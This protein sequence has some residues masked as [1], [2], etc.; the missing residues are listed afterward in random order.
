MPYNLLFISGNAKLTQRLQGAL[1]GEA[2]LMMADPRNE[3]G[4]SLATR[5]DP[6][7]LIV[8]AGTHTGAKTVL[9]SIAAM[10]QKFPTLPLIV[11]GDE[12]SAQLIL[13]SF[14]AGANDFLDRES[15]DTELRAAILSRLR[16][17]PA[18]ANRLAS[19]TLIDILSPAPSDE[20]FD[21]ALN[22]A[23]LIA[24]GD[25]ERR[26]L[27]LDFS[28]PASPARLALG[29]ELNFAMPAAIRD[30]AR[31]DR[32]YLDSALA[33]SA[34][35][36]LYVLPLADEAAVANSLPALRDVLVLL[37]MLRSLFDMV[38][39]YWGAFSRQAALSGL[40]GEN[41]HIF[42][43][44]NQRFASIRNAKSL[45]AE[46]EGGNIAHVDP[47]IVIHQLAHNT[48]PT[49]DDMVRAIGGNK[50]L[51][52]RT[53]SAVLIHA[54]NRGRPLSL[55]GP[56]QYSDALRGYLVAAGLLPQASNG[57]NRN[58]FDWLRKV[59]S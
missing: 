39:I 34:E 19:A 22:T 24:V 59:R 35:T 58:L 49:P 55:S 41:R 37:Q 3:D 56:S 45:L 10:H 25:K 15:S 28:L 54:Q 13:S 27:L 16:D 47:A 57:K 32:T 8:D 51:V 12:M 36:G 38:V 6:H 20:D 40:T 29:L 11:I 18:K 50:S 1:G 44:C 46:L 7:G 5:F 33:R 26:V 52:L 30:I 17:N 53:T 43:C 42:L 31:L 2:A 4:Q 48:T 23:A 14:R 21:F 9:E